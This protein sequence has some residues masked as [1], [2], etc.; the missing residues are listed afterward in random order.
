MKNTSNNN[1]N[2]WK[3]IKHHGT[4]TSKTT[5]TA[6]AVYFK[7]PKTPPKRMYHRSQRLHRPGL[8]LDWSW[9]KWSNSAFRPF[10]AVFHVFLCFCLVFLFFVL[11]FS[12]N[13]V[14]TL[15]GSYGSSKEWCPSRC[16]S[17]TAAFDC[18]GSHRV[19]FVMTVCGRSSVTGFWVDLPGVRALFEAKR[20]FAWQAEEIG[21][22]WRIEAWVYVAGARNRT[23]CENRGRR[24]ILWR[25]SKRWQARVIRRIAFYVTGA[26]NPPH[27]CYMF[28]GRKARF[29]RRVAFLEF[30]LEDQFA[31][32]VPAFRMTSGHDFVAGAV[33]LKH[34]SIF[35]EVSQKTL[36]LEVR[37]FSFRGR[38]AENARFGAPH[39]QFSGKSRRK[40][41]V[42]EIRIFSFRGSLAEKRSFWSSGSSVFEE[43]SHKTLVLELRIFSFRGS[44]AEDAR[45]G[46]PDLH[47]SR[48]SRRICSLTRSWC[49]WPKRILTHRS[50]DRDL[51][52]VVLQDPDTEI[53]HKCP[54][55]VVQKNLLQGSCTSGPT[56]SWHKWPKG[57]PHSET[58]ILHKLSHRIL[59]QWSKRI[60]IQWSRRILIQR[61]CTS[62][63]PDTEILYKWSYRILIQ[64]VQK[65]PNTEILRQRSWMIEVVLQDPDTEILQDPDTVV[66]KIALLQEADT[67]GPKDLHTEILKQRP[68]TSCPTGPWYSGPKGS[69]YSGRE[70][71]WYRDLAQ[72]VLE[73]PDTSGPKWSWYRGLVQVVRQDP[74]TS[75]P[76]GSSYRDPETEIL[77]KCYYRI[78]MQVVNTEILRQRSCMIEVVLQDPD[79]E[80]LHK[81]A[82]RILIQ[83]SKRSCQRD[84]VQ[85]LLQDPDTSGPKDPETEIL[86]KLSHRILIQWSKRIPIQWS[87]RI[88]IQRSCTSGP[89]GSW[90]AVQKDPDTE[91]LYKWSYRIL[92]QVV[93]KDKDPQAEVLH[94]WSYRILI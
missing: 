37:I 45:F 13:S 10:F 93:Q 38:L 84:L 4:K 66:Q 18:A 36:V 75:G 87:R 91:I 44:L 27:G 35:A 90:Q 88:L 9:E 40:T 86:H 54:L 60:P 14:S 81:C 76:K 46:S 57:S 1:K 85:V 20:G 62:G 80:I 32:P 21:W 12:P 48:K 77:H 42:L 53:L 24:F 64:V 17:G 11:C 28:W 30:E 2:T 82:Y 6:P 69:R 19:P 73:D 50:W 31:W 23:L 72:V 34:V 22:F 43:V 25:L 29:L 15:W 68:C 70:G 74:D 56:E 26:G 61:S 94:K 89:R 92:R 33:L 49:K 63:H 52:E 78:L 59:I 65:D 39:S 5:K 41:L 58:E 3:H 51:A 83:W 79:T 16:P 71:S 7:G 67:S 8:T 47:F 55:S